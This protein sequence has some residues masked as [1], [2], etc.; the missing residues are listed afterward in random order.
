MT[1]DDATRILSSPIRGQPC[2]IDTND[3]IFEARTPCVGVASMGVTHFGAARLD[4]AQLDGAPGEIAAP[5]ESVV[6]GGSAPPDDALDRH[7][8]ATSSASTLPVRLLSRGRKVK[9]TVSPIWAAACGGVL[10]LIGAVGVVRGSFE[11][12][13]SGRSPAKPAASASEGDGSIT[14]HVRDDLDRPLAGVFVRAGKWRAVSDDSGDATLHPS[15]SESIRLD[16][17][18]PEG[19]EGAPLD[20]VMTKPMWRAST[21]YSYEL[22]CRAL[23]VTQ[24]LAI[25]TEGCGDSEVFV[26]GV[27]VGTTSEGVLRHERRIREAGVVKLELRASSGLCRFEDSP[28]EVAFERAR[29]N[30]EEHFLGKR[31]VMRRKAAPAV[32]APA[33]PYRL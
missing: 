2:A 11:S 21:S 13:E 7:A 30:V 3:E 8:G 4:A 29:P 12:S 25:T 22:T 24:A 31:P 9:A 5:D 1:D 27:S 15:T 18:C 28:R 14:V 32:S 19:T 16:A 23:E 6:A 10:G 26:D 17:K 33:R 20:R